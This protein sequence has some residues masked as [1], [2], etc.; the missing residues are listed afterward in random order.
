MYLLDRIALLDMQKRAKIEHHV[1]TE[2][3]E[4]WQSNV[5]FGQRFV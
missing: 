2:N 1:K 4:N 3:A 5:Q